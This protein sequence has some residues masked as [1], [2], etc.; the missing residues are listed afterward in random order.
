[1]KFSLRNK[2]GVVAETTLLKAKVTTL[3]R[4][5]SLLLSAGDTPGE[6]QGGFEVHNSLEAGGRRWI[7]LMHIARSVLNWS[8]LPSD[9]KIKMHSTS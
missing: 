2:V 5:Q 1:L 4:Q 6:Q 9:F 3:L 7:S 8:E